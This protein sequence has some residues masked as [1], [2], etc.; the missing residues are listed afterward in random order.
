MAEI[1]KLSLTSS[2]IK[3]Q[4]IDKYLTRQLELALDYVRRSAVGRR[5]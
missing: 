3:T 5:F 2:D 1:D 4:Q